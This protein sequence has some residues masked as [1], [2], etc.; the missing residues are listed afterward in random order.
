MS[1]SLAGKRA[2]VCGASAGIGRAIAEALAAKGATIL[3]LARRESELTSLISS[4]PGAGH[5]AVV[6]DL[7]DRTGLASK[8]DELLAAGPIHVL[9]H[10]TGGPPSGPILEAEEATFLRFFERHVLSAHL[11]TKKLVPGMREAGYGRIVNVIS[12]S[13]KEPIPG[14]GVSNTIRG[15]MA[16]WAKSVSKELPPGIT[17]NNVL[18][19]YTATERLRSLGEATAKRTGRT[20]DEV[21]ADWLKAIPEGRLADPTEIAAAAAFLASPEASYVRGQSLAVDGGR[22]AGI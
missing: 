11:L 12:T 1:G 20:Y 18:P 22:L 5:A 17:I 4:L 7:D 16:S 2:L 9:I 3:A 19:G 21:E 15:A 14:L 10:N 6:A 13:V 8:V